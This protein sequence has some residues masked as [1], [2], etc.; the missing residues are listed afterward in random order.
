MTVKE[1]KAEE[2]GSPRKRSNA[3]P[4]ICLAQ[5]HDDDDE[6]EFSH[7][8]LPPLAQQ[9][10][11]IGAKA[12]CCAVEESRHLPPTDKGDMGASG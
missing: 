1:R 6:V 9:R 3:N 2:K 4:R 11:I 5:Q 12:Q 8:W 7:I 10:D